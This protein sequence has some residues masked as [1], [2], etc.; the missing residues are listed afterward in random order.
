MRAHSNAFPLALVKKIKIQNTRYKIRRYGERRH[1]LVAYSGRSAQSF[2]YLNVTSI[3][4][5][6]GAIVIV[7]FCDP[8]RLSW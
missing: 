6:K 2:R 1:A 3:V 7:K 5:V 8:H 4:I